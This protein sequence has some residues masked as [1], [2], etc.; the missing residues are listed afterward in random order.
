MVTS[1]EIMAEVEGRTICTNFLET[2]SA[3]PEA[4]A[5]MGICAVISRK[6]VP[7]C[8]EAPSATAEA[9]SKAYVDLVRK[10]AAATLPLVSP[11][12]AQTLG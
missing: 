4:I 12:G 11:I 5:T 8:Q 3:H 7:A 1:D 6:D 2:A 10:S 9:A